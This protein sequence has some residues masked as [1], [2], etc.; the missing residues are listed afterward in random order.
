MPTTQETWGVAF[1]VCASI[2]SSTFL[3]AT[4]AI[5]LGTCHSPYLHRTFRGKGG[6]VGAL[7]SFRSRLARKL[8]GTKGCA[9]GAS[10]LCGLH[11]E[12]G[13]VEAVPGVSAD[14]AQH[15]PLPGAGLG[16]LQ[17]VQGAH[18]EEE[19]FVEAQRG[20]RAHGGLEQGHRVS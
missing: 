3:P 8:G 10:G 14:Q 9:D 15:G 12:G 6:S 4:F 17:L 7:Q 1:R 13:G 5:S 16:R 18:V 19:T 2:L 11:L 20:V